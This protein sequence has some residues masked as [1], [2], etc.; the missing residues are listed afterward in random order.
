VIAELRVRVGPQ[1]A[2]AEAALGQS[3]SMEEAIGLAL[4]VVQEPVSA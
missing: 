4:A 1:V 2:A 3:M